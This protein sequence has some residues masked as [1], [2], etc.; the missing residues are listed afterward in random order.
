M[1]AGITF[2]SAPDT[3]PKLKEDFPKRRWTAGNGLGLGAF[4]LEFKNADGNNIIPYMQ[5]VMIGNP[6]NKP[7][8]SAVKSCDVNFV[9]DPGNI[10]YFENTTVGWRTTDNPLPA[11]NRLG[12]QGLSVMDQGYTFVDVG[13]DIAAEYFEKGVMLTC[14]WQDC[15][16][17]GYNPGDDYKSKET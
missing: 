1:L 10:L 13:V 17:T 2:G 9:P 5:L 3:G 7:Q 11:H 8:I 14:D 4:F 6:N 15:G 16:S 12:V